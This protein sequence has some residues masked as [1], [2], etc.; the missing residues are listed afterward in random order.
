MRELVRSGTISKAIFRFCSFIWIGHRKCFF[1]LTKRLTTK[2]VISATRACVCWH[3]VK[4]TMTTMRLNR[5]WAFFIRPRIQLTICEAAVRTTCDWVLHNRNGSFHTFIAVW[6]SLKLPTA[7]FWDADLRP[8][9]RP[10]HWDNRQAEW[11]EQAK[12]EFL[13]FKSITP[14]NDF[15]MIWLRRKNWCCKSK[16]EKCICKSDEE[17]K[18]AKDN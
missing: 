14:S 6:L 18:K 2:K 4:A 5:E 3:R 17:W 7:I 10:Y 12:K 9:N 15:N 11:W 1:P 13:K 8:I 16:T